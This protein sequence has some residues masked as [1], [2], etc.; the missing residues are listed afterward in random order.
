[1]LPEVADLFID[2]IDCVDPQ[3]GDLMLVAEPDSRAVPSLMTP[4]LKNA[5][6]YVVDI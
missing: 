6:E 2:C 4:G 1:M 5:I 3:V